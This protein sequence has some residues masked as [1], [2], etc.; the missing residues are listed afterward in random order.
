MADAFT[1]RLRSMRLARG[2]TQKELGEAIGGIERGV[3]NY[4]LG[5]RKP[6]YEM[7]I[8]LA[9]YFDCSIDYLVGRVDER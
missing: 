6:N 7:L 1:E 8:A 2:L 4:E 3:Q 5:L 9:N